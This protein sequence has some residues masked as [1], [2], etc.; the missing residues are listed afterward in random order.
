MNPNH[1]HFIPFSGYHDQEPEPIQQKLDALMQRY[2]LDGTE[3]YIAHIVPREQDLFT[4]AQEKQNLVDQL[5]NWH[6][7]RLHHSYWAEPTDFLTKKDYPG[8]VNRFGGEEEVVAYYGDKTGDKMYERWAQE[9]ELA[10]AAGL[11]AVTFHLIDYF[12]IDGLWEFNISRQDVI[13]GMTT[14]TKRL[15]EELEKRG[16]LE[17]G[18]KIELENAGFGLEYGVQRVE[19]YLEVMEKVD[20]KYDKLRVAWDINHLLHAV[21]INNDGKGSFFLTP[22]EITPAMAALQQQYGDD[23]VTFAT[24]WVESQVLDPRLVKKVTALHVSDNTLKTIEYFRN[25]QFTQPYLDEIQALSDPIAQEDYGVNVV[26]T[27]YDSHEPLGITLK[28]FPNILAA[29]EQQPLALV[30]E[31]KNHELDQ[32]AM[33]NQYKTLNMAIK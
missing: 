20:D 33:D 30:H 22:E 27:H 1:E 5:K 13:D 19:D 12:H 15:L 11:D 9:Y 32:N 31:L 16:L 17:N 14:M 8:L 18:P 29:M 7:K 6:T 2:S 23:P 24:K 4:T 26:L 10:T 3:V 25:G 21:G 28:D